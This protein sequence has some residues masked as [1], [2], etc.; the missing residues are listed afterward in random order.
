MTTR[1]TLNTNGKQTRKF[2]TVSKPSQC[3]GVLKIV[4]PSSRQWYGALQF[5]II[6]LQSPCTQ[7]TVQC[8]QRADNR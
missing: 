4:N 6:W 2:I 7:A 8:V 3:T 1:P 5:R